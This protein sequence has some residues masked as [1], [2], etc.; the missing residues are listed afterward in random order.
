MTSTEYRYPYGSEITVLLG[1]RTGTVV[2][3][4]E[5]KGRKVLYVSWHQ[6]PETCDPERPRLD[7]VVAS[8]AVEYPYRP[9]LY[10][11]PAVAADGTVSEL[12]AA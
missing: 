1:A 2:G 7:T 3:H 5:L 9:L 10:P 4:G 12:H 8:Y 11:A 6:G